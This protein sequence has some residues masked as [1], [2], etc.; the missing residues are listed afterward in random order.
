MDLDT[1]RVFAKSLNL[2]GEQLK[3]DCVHY[4]CP[5]AHTKHEKGTDNDP[6]FGISIRPGDTSRVHCFACNYSGDLYDLVLVLRDADYGIGN[7]GLKLARDLIEKEIDG[8]AGILQM[9]ALDLDAP[10][11][12]RDGLHEFPEW[13]LETFPSWG[14]N[15]QVAN[16]LYSRGVPEAVSDALDLRAD[17]REW[18]VCFPIRDF[19]GD[20]RGFH[21]RAIYPEAKPKYRMY[22]YAR[23]TNPTVWLGESWV[24][25]DKVV[26][27]VESVFDLARVYQCYRNVVCPLRA[28]INASQAKRMGDLWRVV[29]IFDGDKAG[30]QARIALG[31]H[32]KNTKARWEHVTL[33]QG[34]DPGG[35]T[36]TAIAGLL[37]QYV[38]LDEILS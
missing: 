30:Q 38:E 14:V 21:G 29:T 9:A 25:F 28:G 2:A 27:V 7:E 22:T 19:K 12:G 13:W 4:S 36:L 35:M 17:T 18:R 33:S 23:N 37:E 16:Y 32:L 6:S 11:V 10:S 5:F 15:S 26:V 8:N 20:L 1:I 3:G 24:D 34:E 31:K